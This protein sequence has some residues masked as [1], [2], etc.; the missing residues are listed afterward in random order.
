MWV[1]WISEFTCIIGLDKMAVLQQY[2]INVCLCVCVCAME[3]NGT[4][5]KIKRLILVSTE[6]ADAH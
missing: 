6:L 2:F 1:Y 3:N 5:S 4:H